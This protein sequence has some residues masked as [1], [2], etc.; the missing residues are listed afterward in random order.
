MHGEKKIAKNLL[1]CCAAAETDTKLEPNAAS[2]LRKIMLMKSILNE[3]GTRIGFKKVYFF[4]KIG[5][6][7]IPTSLIL[8]STF[9]NIR[10]ENFFST[11]L[12]F[13]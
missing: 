7:E 6:I 13:F 12:N 9:G 4:L 11:Y 3:V 5:F 2:C 1:P 10:D 8:F